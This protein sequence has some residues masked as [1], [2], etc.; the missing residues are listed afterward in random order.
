MMLPPTTSWPPNF[1]TP[2]RRPAESRPLRELPPAFL[3]A[4]SNYLLLL[5]SRL[6]GRG[7]LGR[8]L[9]SHGLLRGLL[10]GSFLLGR[11]LRSGRFRSFLGL[12]SLGRGLG[13]SLCL[14]LRLRSFGSL[15][16]FFDLRRGFLLGGGLLLGLGVADCDDAQ[17]RHL[18]AVP[19]LTAIVVP[20]ALL[21]DRDLLALRLGD[22][23][24]R[25]GDLGRVRQIA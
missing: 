11:R 17:Q 4:I 13:R 7:L 10:G 18:L 9:F 8:R 23:L 19:G 5:G 24:G 20:T 22:D 16:S 12:D 2:R 25:D 15:R 21:E 3:C 6:F 14:R 1:F